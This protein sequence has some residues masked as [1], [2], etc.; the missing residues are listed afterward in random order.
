[1]ATLK[2]GNEVQPPN[3][4]RED[5]RP[6]DGVA[7]LISDGENWQ[8]LADRYKVPVMTLIES[9]FATTKPEYI[10]WYLHHYVKCDTTTPDRYNWRFSTSSRHKG[11]LRPGTIFVQPNWQAILI[12]A[13]AATR[14]V[15]VDWVRNMSITTA[16]VDGSTLTIGAGRI[17]SSTTKLGT[18]FTK[19]REGGAPDSLADAWMKFLR[20]A[21]IRYTAGLR[22]VHDGAFP[23][24]EA[25]S[26]EIPFLQAKAT[27]W[28]LLQHGSSSDDSLMGP[29]KFLNIPKAANMATPAAH[30]AMMTHAD[31][32]TRAFTRLRN[33][34]L[35]NQVVGRGHVN[36]LT[37]RVTGIAMAPKIFSEPLDMPEIV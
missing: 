31:W 19:L 9:N 26:P 10:N 16:V 34:A 33:T 11:G 23:M 25:V 36:P 18:F 28:F 1:M 27:P 13:K 14:E 5:Y 32:F 30:Q 35:A 12:A 22:D 2:E 37:R 3:P 21:L 15:V 6:P 7:H 4:V 29:A 20:D 24:F 17:F 8:T